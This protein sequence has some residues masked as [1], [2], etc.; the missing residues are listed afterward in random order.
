M[1]PIDIKRIVVNT[2]LFDYTVND[3]VNMWELKIP[4]ASFPLRHSVNL[5]IDNKNEF[6]IGSYTSYDF[7]NKKM[8]VKE[9][10]FE[11]KID[12]IDKNMIM[13]CIEEVKVAQYD[14]YKK[15]KNYLV[16]KNLQSIKKDF[17]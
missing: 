15:E 11:I 8:V 14:M 9:N 12:F 17:V 16:K 13:K 4:T 2:G 6:L 7:E 3:Y 1:K 5:Y 10:L